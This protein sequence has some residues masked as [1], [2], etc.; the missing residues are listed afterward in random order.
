MRQ[1]FVLSGEQWRGAYAKCI[2][3]ILYSNSHSLLH[4]TTAQRSHLDVTLGSRCCGNI[5]HYFYCIFRGEPIILGALNFQFCDFLQVEF[6]FFFFHQSHWLFSFLYYRSN[7]PHLFTCYHLMRAKLT[8]FKGMAYT[9]T[10]N[11][12]YTRTSRTKLQFKVKRRKVF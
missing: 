5:K 11:W 10:L 12:F 6:F 2:C 3:K 9:N 7:L 1:S 8:Q 4:S